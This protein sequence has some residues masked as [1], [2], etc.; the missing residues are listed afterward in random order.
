MSRS[1]KSDLRLILLVGLVLPIAV[2]L[3]D[4]W[5]LEREYHPGRDAASVQALAFFVFQVGLFGVLCARLIQPPWLLWLLF[6]WCLLLS[7][8]NAITSLSI[9]LGT[10]LLTGQI[11]LLTIWTI[12][13]TTSWKTRLAAALVL[14]PVMWLV[15][16]QSV[17]LFLTCLVLRGRGY[18]LARIDVTS[19]SPNSGSLTDSA[20]NLIQ[21]NIRDVLIWT[22]A[23]TPLLALS[24]LTVFEAPMGREL[25][26]GVLHASVLILALWTAL[27]RGSVWLRWPLSAILTLIAGLIWLD[28]EMY[29]H[30]F[31]GWSWVKWPWF[32]EEHL[33][34]WLWSWDAG[35]EFAL[36]GGMLAATLLIYRVLG[37]RLCRAQ[38]ARNSEPALPMGN[39]LAEARLPTPNLS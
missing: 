35:V 30:Q 24:R 25:T 28:L 33:D 18:R 17:A 3:I 31:A 4:G 10:S 34:Y 29:V 26:R 37:Y 38:R 23:L 12:L 16:V 20:S 36:S 14:M 32:S 9:E 11:G 22:T 7:D 1:S 13:G 15:V 2:T 5:L 27:G 6:A 8:L 39:N 21:F 19:D